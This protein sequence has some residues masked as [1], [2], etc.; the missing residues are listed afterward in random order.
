MT[1]YLDLD[2][3]LVDFVGGACK[4]HG[5]AV[6]D[7]WPEGVWEMGT[8][9]SIATGHKM[10]EDEFWK[11]C[12][13]HEFW[14]NLEWTR[15]GKEILAMCEYFFDS[16]IL[17]SSPCASPFSASGK[18]EWI[19]REL[20]KYRRKYSLSPC[21]HEHASTTKVLVDDSDKNIDAFDAAGGYGI[22][23]PRP[24]NSQSYVDEMIEELRESLK[25]A[26]RHN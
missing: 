21:K 5:I 12:S 8:A 18:I 14:A 19:Q 17:M 25:V 3:V 26:S 22:L 11:P 2:G 24:W 9:L 20:P 15:D 13:S 7:P 16:V 6:P 4:T 10:S 23:V 1:C